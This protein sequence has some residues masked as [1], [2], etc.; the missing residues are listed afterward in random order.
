MHKG[1]TD[2]MHVW[3]RYCIRKDTTVLFAGANNIIAV[4]NPAYKPAQLKIKS[5][6]RALRIG[7]P[8]AK[9][10]TLE[11]MAMPYPDK[12]K[13]MRLAIVNSKTGKVLKNHKFHQ[14]ACATC[15]GKG[16]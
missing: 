14:R 1:Q 15:G 7:T 10:D 12:G 8:E 5:L 9:G 13:N 16:G 11:I 4:Y 6:D 3:N 2:S